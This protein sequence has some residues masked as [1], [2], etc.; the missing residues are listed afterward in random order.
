[1]LAGGVSGALGASA[2]A[3]PAGATGTTGTT[4]APVIIDPY[5]AGPV[6]ATLAADVPIA[7]GGGWVIWSV[8]VTG[9]YGLEGSHGGV[10]RP[11]N[12]APRPQPFDVNVGTSSTGAAVVTFSRCAKTPTLQPLGLG[13]IDPLSGSGCRIHVLNLSTLRETTPAIPHPSGTSD[14][15]ASMWHGRV[16]FARLDPAHHQQVQQVMLWTP[17]RRSLTVLPHGALPT[18][19][20]YKTG[21][22]GMTRSG[23]VQGL[24]YDG[25]LVSFLWQPVAPGVIG[26]AGWEVRA[27]NVASGHSTLVS[28]GFAGEV[29]TGGEDLAAP[30]PPVL[31]GFTVSLVA[32]EANCYV[33]N[34]VFA[35]MNTTV[36]G[37][38]TYADI[39]GIVLGMAEDAGAFF[40]VEAPKPLDETNPTCTAAVPCEIQQIAR[41]TP[42][43]KEPRKPSSPFFF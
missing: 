25:H 29:C 23:A 9:G 20:P 31:D 1:M 40:V 27:D 41:P 2:A 34:S 10:T 43:K 36:G 15:T 3:T 4:A 24:S 37:N 39:R 5:P 19:C 22:A 8:P 35:Q 38:G 17:G 21:C 42:L 28:S 13:A 18:K 6:V 33:F 14:T 26:D 32:L 16:A 12:V 11:L 7:A 30:S